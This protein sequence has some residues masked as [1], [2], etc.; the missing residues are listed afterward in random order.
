MRR[1]QIL[2]MWEQNIV[3]IWLRREA[4]LRQYGIQS[5]A[6]VA[7]QKANVNSTCK[8]LYKREKF[9]YDLNGIRTKSHQ[10]LIIFS[11]C[12]VFS[13]ISFSPPFLL[14]WLTATGHPYHLQTVISTITCQLLDSRPPTL[15]SRSLRLPPRATS[16]PAPYLWGRPAETGPEHVPVIALES[17]LYILYLSCRLNIF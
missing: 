17:R 14:I 9:F 5:S 16:N 3:R 4:S 13:T 6:T 15:A 7:S 8:Y 2:P 10:E 1:R 12:C 11:N